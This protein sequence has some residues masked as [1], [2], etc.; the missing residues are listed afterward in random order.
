MDNI[1]RHSVIVG[2]CNTLPPHGHRLGAANREIG[3]C[4]SGH[5]CA[6]GSKFRRSAFATGDVIRVDIDVRK[7]LV[8]F[9]KNEV[10]ACQSTFDALDPARL[11]AAVTLGSPDDQVTLL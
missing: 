10:N 7:K 8:S 9:Y 4:S 3:Y 5:I 2:V 1:P 6:N 11:H